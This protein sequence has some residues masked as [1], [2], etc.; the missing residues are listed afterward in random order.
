MNFSGSRMSVAQFAVDLL[1]DSRFDSALI[2]ITTRG[3]SEDCSVR[4]A[5]DTSLVETA[6]I[7]AQ[8]Y[9]LVLTNT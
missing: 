4:I 8:N 6:A 2:T 3:M 5:I 9:S 1:V 7:K